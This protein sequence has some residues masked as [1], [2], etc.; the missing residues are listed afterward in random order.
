MLRDR[1]VCGINDDRIQRRLLAETEL[2]FDKSLQK[3]VE[4]ASKY[5]Q[6]LQ[7]KFVCHQVETE[8]A[9]GR[10]EE[11]QRKYLPATE[12]A[13][14]VTGNSTVQPSASLKRRSVTIVGKYGILLELAA[15]ERERGCAQAHQ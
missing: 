7:A 6:D 11:R 9:V 14:D 2:T 10:R 3:A 8:G 1:L 15:I 5:V 12:N 13:T 4:T